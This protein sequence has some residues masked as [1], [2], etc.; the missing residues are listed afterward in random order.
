MIH[1]DELDKVFGSSSWLSS[2]LLFPL[3]GGGFGEPAHRQPHG[4][5]Q[6][7]HPSRSRKQLLSLRTYRT[8]LGEEVWVPQLWEGTPGLDLK[9]CV[10]GRRLVSKR[11]FFVTDDGID[12]S[13]LETE[14]R[15][16]S[17]LITSS[18][19]GTE[20]YER[21]AAELVQSQDASQRFFFSL[22]L[23]Y[24]GLSYKQVTRGI[25]DKSAIKQHKI[26]VIVLA[27]S[28]RLSCYCL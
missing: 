22:T 25:I 24:C 19:S 18:S 8:V 14:E 7:L 17:S 27:N 15:L 4:P 16:I 11:V 21:R 5:E 23:L 1:R 20:P 6:P 3:Q 10:T 9:L 2:A 26:F 28:G 13:E 12:W